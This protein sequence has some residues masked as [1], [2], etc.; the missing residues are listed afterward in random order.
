MSLYNSTY[1]FLTVL[2]WYIC[3]FSFECAL[4]KGRLQVFHQLVW[5]LLLLLEG[6]E[7]PDSE[8]AC[9]LTDC[10]LLDKLVYP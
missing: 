4:T 1:V 2:C 6:I 5:L 9:Q 3:L 7:S 8:R 10:T